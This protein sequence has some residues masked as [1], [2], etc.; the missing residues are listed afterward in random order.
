MSFASFTMILLVFNESLIAC[1]TWNNFLSTICQILWSFVHTILSPLD[2][3]FLLQLYTTHDMGRL[4]KSKVWIL[5]ILL[6]LTSTKHD[7]IR[8]C[9]IILCIFKLI[10]Y[11]YGFTGEL[12]RNLHFRLGLPLDRPLLRTSNALTF[13]GMIGRDKNLSKN[14]I[15]YMHML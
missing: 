6:V 8:G 7:I 4:R 14:G 3:V 10:R 12:R 5:H 13:G 9:I 2:C 1:K 11:L 15:S